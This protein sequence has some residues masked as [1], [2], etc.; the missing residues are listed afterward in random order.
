M[1]PVSP[2]NIKV[3]KIDSGAKLRVS[4]DLLTP[5]EARG[6]VTDYIVSYR[7]ESRKRQTSEKI[8]PGTESSTI[9]EGLDPNQEYSVVVRADTKAGKGETSEPV[10]TICKS[11]SVNKFQ[12]IL[13]SHDFLH[14]E[15]KWNFS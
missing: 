10:S 8:V 4:W 12:I 15:C 11:T 14:A 6:F 7:S 13:N 1:P 2:S 9:I 5:E 3:E